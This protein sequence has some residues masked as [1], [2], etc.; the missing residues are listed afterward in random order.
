MTDEVNTYRYLFR[1]FAHYNI[2]CVNSDKTADYVSY[3]NIVPLCAESFRLWVL[4]PGGSSCSTR[5]VSSACDW[6]TFRRPR[7]LT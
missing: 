2:C 6:S 3:H 4:L 5:D 7:D 1:I